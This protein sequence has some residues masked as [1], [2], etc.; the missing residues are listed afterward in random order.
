VGTFLYKNGSLSFQPVL[1]RK[2]KLSEI[3]CVPINKNRDETA[4]RKL[5]LGTT[6]AS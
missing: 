3:A 6:L 4:Q 5:S 2:L 1:E